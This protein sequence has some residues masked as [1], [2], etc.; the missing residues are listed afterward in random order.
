[1]SRKPNIKKLFILYDGRAHADEDDATVLC[2]AY[3]EREAKEDKEMFPEDSL[4]FEYEVVEG[5]ELV[6]GRARYDL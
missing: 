2:T 6:N 1:M 5:K 4:W 3:N